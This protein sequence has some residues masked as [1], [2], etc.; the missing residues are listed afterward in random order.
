[1]VCASPTTSE[2]I[3]LGR[4]LEMKAY[5][6]LPLRPPPAGRTYQGPFGYVVSE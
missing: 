5:K 3:L 6:R 4:F 1:M 2:T